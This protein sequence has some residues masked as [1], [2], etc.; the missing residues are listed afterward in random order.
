MKPK[1]L[2]I[3]ISEF[4]FFLFPFQLVGHKIPAHGKLYSGGTSV[5]GKIS[6]GL[7]FEVTLVQIYRVAL[8]A[9]K[10]HR[11]HKHHHAHH[12]DH[13]GQ[14]IHPT[15]KGTPVVSFN[16]KDI[17]KNNRKNWGVLLKNIFFSYAI[18]WRTNL[19]QDY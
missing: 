18:I 5:T 4:C 2:S 6:E 9:G 15:T 16:L 17:N 10:A 13:E 7:H 14:E 19:R 3:N 12:F 8:S 1:Q 11:D